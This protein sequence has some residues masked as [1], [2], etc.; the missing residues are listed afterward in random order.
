MLTRLISEQ[1]AKDGKE[2]NLFICES[3][4]DNLRY[5]DLF[6]MVSLHKTVKY[7]SLNYIVFKI[8]STCEYTQIYDMSELGID[9][10]YLIENIS[11]EPHIIYN[12]FVC[13]KGISLSMSISNC[14]DL[15]LENNLDG[16]FIVDEFFDKMQELDDSITVLVKVHGYYNKFTKGKEKGLHKLEHLTRNLNDVKFPY[17]LVYEY[18]P[19]STHG[20][21][22]SEFPI[23]YHEETT[24]MK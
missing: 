5:D 2:F 3:M 7:N 14:R 11:K 17:A 23:V 19:P 22:L 9:K 6:N 16:E 13:P 8:N 1:I 20:V 4:F 15:V 24:V 18:M 21:K 10:N 12:G